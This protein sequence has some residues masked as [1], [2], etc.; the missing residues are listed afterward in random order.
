M[1][2]LDNAA[3]TR[4][5][6]EAAGAMIPFLTEQYGNPSSVYQLARKSRE[7][8][9]RSRECISKMLGAA[10]EEIIFTSGG[11]ESDNWALT[12]A[13]E[14][15]KEKG[16]HIITS[17]IEHPAVLRT[18]EYLERVRGARITWLDVDACGRIDLAQAEAAIC[19]E[20]ILLSVMFAN[21]EVGTLQPVAELG[22]MARGRGIL[23]HTDAVQAFGHLPIYVDELGIDMLSASGHKFHGPKGC[24]FLYLRKGSGI[25]AL[26]HGGGQEFNRRAGTENVPG[27]VAMGVAAEQAAEAMEERIASETAL[28]DYFAERVLQEIPDVSC[29]GHPKLRL[30]NNISCTF[31]GL[32]AESILI[33]L[34]L[35]GICASGGS[36]CSSGSIDPSHVLLAMGRPREEAFGTVRFTISHETTREELDRTIETLKMIVERLRKNLPGAER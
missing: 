22:A 11:T 20:T 30:P 17:R 2:Y 24:G 31:H 6:P 5:S 21:N 18:C 33:M 23:F 16:N 3:T 9:R 15:C 27:I 35:Q 28:R 14:A 8:I 29:N 32:S 13:F 26:L 25:G 10:P 7:A 4:M 19:P 34:D 36:A 12:A 1:I